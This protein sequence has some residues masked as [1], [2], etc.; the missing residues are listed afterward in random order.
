MSETF[1]NNN[2]QT[3]NK[4]TNIHCTMDILSVLGVTGD[5]DYYMS[6]LFFLHSNLFRQVF[7]LVSLGVFLCLWINEWAYD[8]NFISTGHDLWCTFWRTVSAFYRQ[9]SIINQ[10]PIYT[11]LLSLVYVGHWYIKVSVNVISIWTERSSAFAMGTAAR[12]LVHVTVLGSFLLTS[13]FGYQ[14]PYLLKFV[15]IVLDVEVTTDL[16]IN[17]RICRI[18]FTKPLVDGCV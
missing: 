2:Y 8:V 10:R 3:N 6:D 4:L 5:S 11:N 7:L 15:D 18:V 14:C 17:L 13:C 12:F 1:W 16:I 9:S